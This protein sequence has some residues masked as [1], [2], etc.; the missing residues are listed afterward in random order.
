MK[1][2]VLIVMLVAFTLLISNLAMAGGRH[3]R[4]HYYGGGPNNHY[5]G[6]HGRGGNYAGAA[7]GGLIVGGIIGSSVN[8]YYRRPVYVTPYPASIPTGSTF[9]L[10]SSGD[11]FLISYSANGSKILSS[12]PASNC[13]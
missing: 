1:K 4:G 7:L 11:C 12:V 13:K 10:N 8:P 3:S 5:Y 2:S 6:G 9:L